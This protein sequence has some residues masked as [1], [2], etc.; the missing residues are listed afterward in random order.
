MCHWC[1]K[2]PVFNSETLACSYWE[3]SLFE[4]NVIIIPF[5]CPFTYLTATSIQQV[6]SV[7]LPRY[8]SKAQ[9]H[10]VKFF[11][12]FLN[13]QLWYFCYSQCILYDVHRRK[14]RLIE[15]NTKCRY[16]QKKLPVKGLCGRYLSV[17]GPD[18]ISP[19]PYTLYT[20]IQYIHTGK[21]WEGGRLEPE[22]RFEWQHFKKL[23]LKYQHDWLYQM[24]LQS[25]NSDKHLT[26]SLFAGQSFYMTTFCFGDYIV[27]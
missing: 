4:N 20:C 22:R 2:C 24:Y 14:I 3:Y 17:W 12:I 27:N 5:N 10:V 7:G 1:V 8:A 9:R 19:P 26:Q 6:D 16:L 15:G 18:P 13:I 25:I 11:K 23:G 21:G